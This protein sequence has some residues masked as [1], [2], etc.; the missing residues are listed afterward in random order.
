MKTK[1][2]NRIRVIKKDCELGTIYHC[3]SRTINK[4]FLWDDQ[5]KEVLRRQ[6]RKVAAF[7]GVDI[8]AYCLMSNHF[9]I[10]VR[11][12][13]GRSAS[14]T[15]GELLEKLRDF[16]NNPEDIPTLSKLQKELTSEEAWRREA[17]RNMLLARM[18]DLS[19][20]MKI[21]KQ[22]FSIWYNRNHRR[23][24]PHWCDRFQSVL[25]QNSRSALRMVAAYIA[26]NPVRA[27]ICKDP[28]DYRYS[29]YAEAMLGNKTA[30]WGLMAIT[31]E[32][33]FQSALAIF[34]Q[35]TE[36][37]GGIPKTDVKVAVSGSQEA[38]EI[39]LPNADGKSAWKQL[40]TVKI[41]HFTRGVA[42]G[43]AD[44]LEELIRD[45]II[46][47]TKKTRVRAFANQELQALRG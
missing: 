18:D 10:L 35:W 45:G 3:V 47:L 26:L 31:G 36:V 42:I 5:A 41:R 30:L 2:N 29:S 46:K 20:F 32:Q 16:Y 25:V 37:I 4:E 6:I 27:G 23:L 1:T 14:L 22:R 24:G 8:L 39:S 12:V 15:T 17:S 21:L 40:L 44:Y 34:H 19:N 13:S 38:V 33:E 11:V 9:H 7:C 28:R 43:T